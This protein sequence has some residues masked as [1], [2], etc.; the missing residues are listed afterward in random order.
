MKVHIIL[1]QMNGHKFFL[2]SHL[3][4]IL[5][6][7]AI[8]TY[9]CHSILCYCRNLKTMQFVII[10]TASRV[11]TSS[12]THKIRNTWASDNRLVEISCRKL[13]NYYY[14]KNRI[15]YAAYC[16]LQ[17]FRVLLTR[18]CPQLASEVHNTNKTAI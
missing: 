1:T 18:L 5:Y 6:S 3:Y 15:S 13:Q 7:K 17:H 11:T 14:L 2:D 12:R 8:H 9:S 16:I 10:Y 4:V